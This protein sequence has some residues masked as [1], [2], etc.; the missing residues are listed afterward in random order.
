MA[1]KSKFTG[2][3]ID[4]YLEKVSSGDLGIVVD[5]SLSLESENAVQNKVI[6]SSLNKV[7]DKLTNMESSLELCED[8]IQS[9]SLKVDAIDIRMNLVESKND[10]TITLVNSFDGRISKVESDMSVVL[11]KVEDSTSKVES[12]ESRMV[13]IEKTV[14]AMDDK[15]EELHADANTEGSV[16]YK[17]SHALAWEEIKE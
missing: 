5:S 11:T 10:T 12:F 1:Y 16:D 9:L 8:S 7:Y 13:E 3:Q 14:E 15:I 2:E 4:Y 6:A 17:I